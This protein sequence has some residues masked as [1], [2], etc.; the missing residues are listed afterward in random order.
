M[1][2]LA[3]LGRPM[4]SSPS[5]APEVDSNAGNTR[6]RPYRQAAIHRPFCSASATANHSLK[7]FRS[8]QGWASLI[9]SVWK[10]QEVVHVIAQFSCRETPSAIELSCPR[11]G[12][13][14]TA[15][16][17]SFSARRCKLTRSSRG[18]MLHRRCAPC[19][20]LELGRLA[21]WSSG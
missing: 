9:K 4:W 14:A 1:K 13:Q 2:W 7:A 16:I 6:H 19:I 17:A 3:A 21:P 15:V 20:F 18:A 8:A 5:L 12:T 10:P 11:M